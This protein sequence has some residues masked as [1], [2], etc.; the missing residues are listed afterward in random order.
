MTIIEEKYNWNGSLTYVK[1]NQKDMII[2]HHAAASSCTAQDIH[3]W[4]LNNGWAGIGYHYFIRKDGRIYRGRP[5]MTIGAHTEGYNTRGIGVCCEGDYTQGTMPAAQKAALIELIKDIK[6]RT[7]IS[8]IKM[9][10]DLNATSCPGK[11][12]PE[13]EI[14]AAVIG[15]AAEPPKTGVVSNKKEVC[16]VNLPLLGKGDK[17]NSV[18]ALQQ[19]LIA[20]GY[21]C[22]G[23]GADGS[24]GAG[25]ETSVRAYQ[26]A[27]GLAVDGIVGTKTWSSL[28]L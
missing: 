16:E 15:Q 17:G 21:N 28:L 1:S 7:G 6:A 26:G 19:L 3:R 18:K 5:E 23:Y 11:N 4:H 10:R 20:R 27:N 24:F 9:H 8:T 12:F 22:G 25:T 13:D 2:L 14:R